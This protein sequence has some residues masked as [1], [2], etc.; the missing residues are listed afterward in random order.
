MSTLSDGKDFG[1]V[2]GIERPPELD[3]LLSNPLQERRQQCQVDNTFR[4]DANLCAH[5]SFAPAVAPSKPL[6]HASPSDFPKLS[7]AL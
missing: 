5:G 3:T 7:C 6:V 1:D 2:L 4:N